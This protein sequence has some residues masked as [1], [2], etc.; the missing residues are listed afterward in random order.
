MQSLYST[1]SCSKLLYLFKYNNIPYAFVGVRGSEPGKTRKALLRGCSVCQGRVC[2]Q[3]HAG[4]VGTSHPVF[5]LKFLVVLRIRGMF[6]P[7]PNF[8]YPGPRI[9]D[10]KDPRIRICNPNLSILTQTIIT[11]LSEIWSKIFILD[12]DPGS[13]SWF[14]A[15]PGSRIQGSKRHRIPDPGSG[16]ATLV[17]RFLFTL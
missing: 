9:Q 17:S 8:F 14:F 16:S 2:R 12:P 5:Y 1:I 11:K 15:H 3:G 7:D 6:I 13:G 4:E 10:Q